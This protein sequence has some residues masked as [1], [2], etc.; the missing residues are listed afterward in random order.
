MKLYVWAILAVAVV[1][2]IGWILTY[3]K[4]R[5]EKALLAKFNAGKDTTVAKVIEMF[6]EKEKE[7]LAKAV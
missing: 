4:L 2:T 1:A 6:D 7:L 5:K 3:G